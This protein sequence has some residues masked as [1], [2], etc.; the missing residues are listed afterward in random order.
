MRHL[1]ECPNVA[2]LPNS[3]RLHLFRFA[4]NVSAE[5]SSGRCSVYATLFLYTQITSKG[6][7]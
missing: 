7:I 2:L 4:A 3:K 6:A 1:L 5:Y